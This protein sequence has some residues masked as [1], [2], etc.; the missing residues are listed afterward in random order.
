MCHR[1]TPVKLL[2][3][4]MQKS[5]MFTSCSAARPLQFRSWSLTLRAWPSGMGVREGS[6]S[7][8]SYPSLTLSTKRLCDLDHQA[9]LP[10]S[11]TVSIPQFEALSWM[12]SNNSSKKMM[13]FIG[14]Y[15]DGGGKLW[16][17]PLRWEAKMRT[18][19]IS[20]LIKTNEDNKEHIEIILQDLMERK[21]ILNEH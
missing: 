6:S 2:N 11:W 21:A 18:L 17:L 1:M 19:A 8:K 3:L 5:R 20:K 4:T 14:S 13:A 10:A 12:K 15:N 7:S 16:T 9:M